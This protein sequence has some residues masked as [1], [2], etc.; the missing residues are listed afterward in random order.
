MIE[1]EVERISNEVH[2]LRAAEAACVY[3]ELA[4]A[5]IRDAAHRS[6]GI[7]P[8][9]PCAARCRLLRNCPSPAV[10]PGREASDLRRL[11]GGADGHQSR[12]KAVP[13]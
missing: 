7:L 6:H 4:K 8:A 13:Q 10:A 11:F 2:E 5:A 9:H 3:G 12:N 1:E